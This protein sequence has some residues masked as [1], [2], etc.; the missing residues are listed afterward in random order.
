MRFSP[1]HA[2]ALA[3]F[4]FLSDQLSLCAAI[5][6]LMLSASGGRVAWNETQHCRL[7][8]GAA[9]EPL[10]QL[11]RRHLEAMPSAVEAAV[12]AKRL[13]QETFA[14][15]R[16]NCSALREAP[17]F[18]PVLLR[19]TRESAFVYALS[20]AAITHSIARACGLGQ[21]PLCSC[22][23]TP[24]EEPQ[25][26]FRWGGCGDNLRFGLHLGS[27]IADGPV[28]S[29]K[30]GTRASRLVDLHNN[31]VGRQVLTDSLDTKC[32]CHGVSGSCSVKTCWKSLRNLADTAL[33]L[34]SRYLTASRVGYRSVGGRRQL[35]P[36][37]L[38]PQPL[39]E[40]QLVYLTRSPDYCVKN[41]RTGSLGT[42]DRPCNK[43]SAGSDSCSRLCCG[44]GY[45]TYTERVEE[46]CH[47]KYHWCCYVLC[48][49]CQRT[50]E[51]HVCK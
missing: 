28:K 11:C 6:W 33:E 40:A 22:G 31:A 24:S 12:Q 45:N 27:A 20:A 4:L 44:R 5:Q 48:K 19:G 37:G 36:K 13:C 25:P 18:A 39:D 43:T 3:S 47:C 38:D 50:V 29:H 51:R 8:E 42:E 7:L 15:M 49:K 2:A 17:G 16:W 41:P 9:T 30:M 26:D 35:V 10:A 1:W 21:L 14:D 34:K 23:A 46:R 32:Q